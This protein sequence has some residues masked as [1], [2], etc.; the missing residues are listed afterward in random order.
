MDKR[1]DAGRAFVPK[2]F[3][4]YP[5]M[6]MKDEVTRLVLADLGNASVSPLNVLQHSRQ[7]KIAFDSGEEMSL[8]FDQ[9]VSYWRVSSWSQS[10]SKGAW[11]DFGNSNPETQAVRIKTLDL[12]IEGHLHQLSYSLSSERI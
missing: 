12:Q 10:G 11:F 9:G 2:V 8:R 6:G 4:D 7:L 3:A 5:T 1:H